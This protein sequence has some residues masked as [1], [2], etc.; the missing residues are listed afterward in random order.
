MRSKA[1]LTMIEQK[2][3]W[4]KLISPIQQK[5]EALRS[6][7][8]AGQKRHELIVIVKCFLLIIII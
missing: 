7:A 1:A 3:N 2:V 8:P 6:D 4:D 5:I